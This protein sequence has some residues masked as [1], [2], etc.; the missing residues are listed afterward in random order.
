[1]DPS[2]FMMTLTLLIALLGLDSWMKLVDY[3]NMLIY[4]KLYHLLLI[5]SYL[6]VF[7][8]QQEMEDF[9]YSCW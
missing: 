9:P 8:D 2:S 1:M 6:L 5:S 4:L 7:R 3:F